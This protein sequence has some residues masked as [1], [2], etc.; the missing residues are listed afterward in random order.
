M[1]A[2]DRLIFTFFDGAGE[3][4]VDPLVTLR[5]MR[6][7]ECNFEAEL[8]FL[9][10]SDDETLREAAWEKLVAASREVFDI[11]PL[12]NDGNGLTEQESFDVLDRFG[13]FLDTLKKNTSL[14]PTSPPSSELPACPGS[15]ETANTNVLSASG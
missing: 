8:A 13:E 15:V 12:S 14:K 2:T 4:R 6:A 3:R 11:T 10:E 1:P 5:R 7:H 9:N